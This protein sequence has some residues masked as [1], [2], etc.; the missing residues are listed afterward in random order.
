MPPSGNRFNHMVTRETVAGPVDLPDCWAQALASEFTAPYFSDLEAFVAAERVAGDV[1][2]PAGDVFNALK[3]TPLERVRV[4]ILGQD[5]YHDVGQAHG[6][7]FSVRSG[8]RLP[9]SLRNIFKELEADIGLASGANGCLEAWARQGV[10]LLN[11]VLTVRAH[12]ANSH[13]N[14][15]WETLTDKVI[16]CVNARPAIVFVLWGRP[17]QKKRVRIDQRHFVIESTHP[18]PLSASR[19]FFGSRPFSRINAFLA[20]RGEPEIDWRVVD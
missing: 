6:L 7:S 14:H 10:L 9:P 20:G 5:P 15:G 16:D 19:G 4:V 18:S 3:L 11:T 8:V 1:F 13:R 2:P 17:A 12:D